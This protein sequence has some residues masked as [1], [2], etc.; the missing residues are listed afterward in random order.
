M[1]ADTS[2]KGSFQHL[3][4]VA[5]RGRLAYR[6]YYSCRWH[7]N[8]LPP[9]TKSRKS[10][11]SVNPY[12]VPEIY[13]LTSPQYE[14]TPQNTTTVPVKIPIYLPLNTQPNRPPRTCPPKLS[15][16]SVVCPTVV[17]ERIPRLPD[18]TPN[19]HHLREATV[20][21]LGHSKLGHEFTNGHVA[22]NFVHGIVEML[23]Q[24]P[25]MVAWA[26][27]IPKKVDRY[28]LFW[29]DI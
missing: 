25:W 27:S 18:I 10:S 22:G 8:V 1:A 3:E 29:T 26:G 17:S 24:S 19:L 11:Q 5:R 28:G 2:P 9:P 15:Q 13:P 7:T 21:L 4:N 12:C 6:I 20:P 14:E 23:V 16:S